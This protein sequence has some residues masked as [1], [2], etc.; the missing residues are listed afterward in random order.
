MVKMPSSLFPGEVLRRLPITVNSAQQ[1]WG[2]FVKISGHD[3]SG[4]PVHLRLYLCDWVVE[5]GG[6][7][8]AESA[9]I[10]ETNR[11]GLSLVVGCEINA[12]LVDSSQYHVTV[13]CSD[14][15]QISLTANLDEYESDDQMFLMYLPDLNLS[16]SPKVGLVME[17]RSSANPP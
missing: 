11:R 14:G 1:Y 7:T 16:F 8:V 6:A 4:A 3:P 12:F 2:S 13:V 5:Q 10:V 9:S 17:P 15:L